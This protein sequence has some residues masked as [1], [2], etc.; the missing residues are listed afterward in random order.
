MS[1]FLSGPVWSAPGWLRWQRFGGP[2]S[3]K[4]VRSW[5]PNWGPPL[6]ES[7]VYRLRRRD[8]QYRWVFSRTQS[9]LG[10]DDQLNGHNGIT[11]EIHDQVELQRQLQCTNVNLDNFI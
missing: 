10:L 1:R 3:P 7:P 9:V 5:S 6:L 4:T 2:F 11:L 8:G